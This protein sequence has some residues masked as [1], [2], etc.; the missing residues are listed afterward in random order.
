MK[1]VSKQHHWYLGSTSCDRESCWKE[2]LLLS[3]RG[4]SVFFQMLVKAQKVGKTSPFLV[5]DSPL[6]FWPSHGWDP[7]Q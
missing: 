1:K 4:F 3:A 7:Q 6:R 5:W 2:K